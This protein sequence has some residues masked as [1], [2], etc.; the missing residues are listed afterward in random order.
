MKLVKKIR[1]K[2]PAYLALA[3]SVG[4]L[5]YATPTIVDGLGI[6]VNFEGFNPFEEEEET[7]NNIKPEEKDKKAK[8]KNCNNQE[9]SAEENEESKSK[10]QDSS[11]DE[12]NELESAFQN[13]DTLEQ[14]S[15]AITTVK[16]ELYDSYM[17]YVD[18]V[19]NKM[20]DVTTKR[21][22][23]GDFAMYET[24]LKNG[25]ISYGDFKYS[26][27]TVEINDFRGASVIL[28]EGVC[29][30]Q[31][32]NMA[33]VF[34]S[35]GY[36]AK[37]VIGKYYN[38][39]E[40]KPTYANHAVVYVS[41]GKFAYLLDPTNDTILLRSSHLMYHSIESQEYSIICFEPSIIYYNAHYGFYQS[42]ELLG[43]FFN[44]HKKHWDVLKAYKN[45][46]EAYQAYIS[47]FNEFEKEEL[48][49]YEEYYNE[50]YTAIIEQ[51]KNIITDDEESVKGLLR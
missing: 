17:E 47:E 10:E 4:L 30:N 25:C 27:P 14:L 34:T 28:G 8:K 13:A 36:D 7:E 49:E 44:D 11:E 15:S 48:V 35:L 46:K 39:G 9:E 41:D 1:K 5:G 24:M 18:A 42:M 29:L 20:S 50:I 38:E 23:V 21:D 3:F 37:V 43:D 31:A 12:K 32:H 45:Y 16:D 40:E 33:D 26:M 22:I 6:E 19:A 2:L 51:L